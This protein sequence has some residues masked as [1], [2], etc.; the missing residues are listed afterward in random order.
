MGN[1]VNGKRKLIVVTGINRGLG[2]T[3][4]ELFGRTKIPYT[5]VGT[6]RDV[7]K[8]AQVLEQFKT[9][10][11]QIKFHFHNLDL[12]GDKKTVEDFYSWF[13]KQKLGKIDVLVNNVG[14]GGV[15][16]F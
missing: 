5:I 2:K 7:Q 11:P 16:W 6:V 10:F 9:Q 14:I 4:I 3:L 12:N 13:S 8:E 1:K 15:D